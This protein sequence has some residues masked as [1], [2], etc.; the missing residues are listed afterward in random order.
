MARNKGSILRPPAAVEN[1]YTRRLRAIMRAVGEAFAE[2]VRSTLDARSDGIR[3]TPAIADMVGRAFDEMLLN[4]SRST[5]RGLAKFGVQTKKPRGDGL[6]VSAL[7]GNKKLQKALA[8]RR[9]ENIQLVRDVSDET[10]SS[11]LEIL[12]DAGPGI[13]WE[14][15]AKQI[16]ERTSV[17]ESRAE[18]I[19]RDQCLS[20]AAQIS[21][22]LQRQAGFDKYEWS[23]SGD[24]RVREEH[25]DYNGRVFA[26]DDPPEDGHPGEA[27]LC[28]CVAVP[29]IED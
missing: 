6:G 14:D 3:A 1:A 9:A 21:E 22:T 28:R 10:R 18:L 11:M 19:A 29:V 13:R 7:K 27:I 4:T 12:S 5:L 16:E 15:V 26:W 25:A 24:D 2:D 20:A 17:G 23:T 8:T